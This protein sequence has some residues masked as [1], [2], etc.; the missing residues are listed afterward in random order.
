MSTTSLVYNFIFKKGGKIDTKQTESYPK[1]ANLNR[2]IELLPNK[3]TGESLRL[4]RE[5]CNR[6]QGKYSQILPI[7]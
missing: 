1:S 4:D 2:N 7:R 6:I 5:L 3:H